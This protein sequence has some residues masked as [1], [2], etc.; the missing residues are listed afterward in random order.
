MLN[1]TLLTKRHHVREDGTKSMAVYSACE[2]YRYALERCWRSDPARWMI[3]IMLNPSTA[4]HIDNDPT[5]ERCE[6][7]A[8]DWGYD[9]ILVLNLFAYR[10]T[11]PKKMKKQEHPEGPLNN[12]TITEALER[13]AAFPDN[14]L[15]LCGWGVHGAH[16]GRADLIL[17]LMRGYG[18]TPLALG[19]TRNGHPQHPLYIGY[20]KKPVE[21]PAS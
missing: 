6:R 18:V 14:H 12:W 13:A 15:V 10:A 2:N 8:R 5:V 20:D 7:R 3:M 16:K 21:R 4:T 1:N 19:W 9:G 17:S 11:D